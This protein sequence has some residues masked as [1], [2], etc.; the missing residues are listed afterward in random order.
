MGLMAGDAHHHGVTDDVVHLVALEHRLRQR[1]ATRLRLESR[2]AHAP[3]LHPG[4][5]TVVDHRVELSALA[6]ENRQ[7]PSPAPS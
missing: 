4:L 5:L 7:R 6:V 1:N 3:D 2:A